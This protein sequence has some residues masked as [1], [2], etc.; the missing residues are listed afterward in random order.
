MSFVLFPELKYADI[1]FFILVLLTLYK[2]IPFKESRFANDPHLAML[3]DSHIE[4]IDQDELNRKELAEHLATCILN[5]QSA[6]SFAIGVSA[7]WGEGKTS[8]QQMVKEYLRQK[9]A[10]AILIDF[11]PWKSADEN[12]IVADFFEILSSSIKK[13][14][15]RLGKLVESYGRSFLSDNRSWWS[16]LIQLFYSSASIPESQFLDINNSL[17]NIGR[18]IVVFVDDIDRL[19]GGEIL[20]V[21]KL[22]RNSA[23]F[24][25][26]FFVVGF[27][28]E[29][30]NDTI[31]GNG[32]FGG[33]KFLEKIFQIQIELGPIPAE[34]IKRRLEH[35]IVERH[36]GVRLK[37]HDPEKFFLT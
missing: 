30:L 1:A 7:K 31:K 18:K 33:S 23:N 27:D 9:D 6:R 22:I 32:K 20:E 5:T 16:K 11:N 4:T 34:L 15:F 2:V 8:F 28:H 29:Y 26:T 24:R 12:R 13:Y 36:V 10:K 3:N 35:L 17:A 14:H 21:V 19:N 25:N 37:I